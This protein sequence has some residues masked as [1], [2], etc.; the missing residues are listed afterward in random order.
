MTF[1]DSDAADVREG[2]TVL[3]SGL[4]D[5]FPRGLVLGRVLKVERD[6]RYSRLTAQVE[7]A[8]PFDQVSAVNVR[9]GA[10]Q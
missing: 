1:L 5:I 7:P 4:S 8:V 6:K 9:I 3:T 10:G 2:D